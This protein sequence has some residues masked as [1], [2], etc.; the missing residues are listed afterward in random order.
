MIATA[1]SKKS[2]TSHVIS[3]AKF[4][5]FFQT[6]ANPAVDKEDLKCYSDFINHKF[7][8]LLLRGEATAKA[9]SRVFMGRSICRLPTAF[10]NI[11][12]NSR[13]RAKRSTRGQFLEQL[14][15]RPP[16]NPSY[17]EDVEDRLPEIA[18]R[19]E[20]SARSH[21]W[22]H[23]CQS[24]EPGIRARAEVLSH[25]RSAAVVCDNGRVVGA[26]FSWIQR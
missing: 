13:S 18:G 17:G 21:L 22:H 25:F 6:V 15:A 4:Q 10:R 5:R 3:V 9:N 2:S 7:H 1:Q 23:R 14:A 16:L 26:A 11:S 12:R 19:L 20:R 24:E 8:D